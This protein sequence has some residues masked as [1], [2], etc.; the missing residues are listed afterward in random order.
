MK[1][2]NN[3]AGIGR[4]GTL[5]SLFNLIL[6]IKYYREKGINAFKLSPFR[7]VRRLRE[8]RYGMV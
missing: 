7:E 4:T 5:I 2:C 3:S 1:F 8:Q 6:Q